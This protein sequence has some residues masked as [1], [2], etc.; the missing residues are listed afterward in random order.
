MVECR[1]ESFIEVSYKTPMSFQTRLMFPSRCRKLVESMY[2]L[3]AKNCE[4]HITQVRGTEF[5][6][7]GIAFPTFMPETG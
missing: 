6:Q 4:L 2:A 1:G 5:P 7:S 3:G